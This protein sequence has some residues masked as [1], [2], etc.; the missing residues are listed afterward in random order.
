[1]PSFTWLTLSQAQTALAARLADPNMVFW[2]GP[3]L[4][5]YLCESLRTW[6][7]LTEQWNQ[8]FP[9]TATPNKN[10]YNLSTLPGSP[11]LRTVTDAYLYTVMQYHLLEPP[12]GAG[13]WTGTSQF[14]LA[15]LQFALQRRRDEM[16]QATGCNLT[17][18]PK[19]PS[20]PNTRRTYF[21]DSTLEPIRAR[22]VPDSGSIFFDS[23]TPITLT[24]EDTA[25]WD[26]FE[27]GYL[28]T[29]GKPASWSV[30]AGP[31]LAM[32]VDIA[33]NVAGAYDVIALFS[34]LQFSPPVPT[35]LGVP[36]DWSWLAKWGALA[37]LLGRESEATDRQRADYCLKRYSD[38]LKV[39]RQSNWL[40]AATVNGLVVDTP[41]LREMDGF[42][43]EWEN[44]A[45]AWPS[46]V[47]AGI[48]FVAGCPIGNLMG[49]N[50]LVVGNCPVPVNPSDYVQVSRDVWDVVLDYAQSL[51][52]LKS[53]GNEFKE[54][55]YLE[56]NFF[57][58]AMETN[59]RLAKLGLFRDILGLEGN[60]QNINQPR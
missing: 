53:G 50:V 13:I 4:L 56:K 25:A 10:W 36:D 2:S 22:F 35:L 26:S 59:K 54:C 16:I 31:P 9:F 1:M 30:I 17:N 21:P 46:V 8:N 47:T 3:E 48:D 49:I 44:N 58:L 52:M 29:L 55:A 33:P 18:L 60:R 32:D 7:A 39:M 6:N 20:V 14:S 15:D 24:R 51:A 11:R 38:G 42:S 45:S 34:G 23:S 40:L 19:L 37:D 28:Q 5:M 41:S 43:P 12:T 57:A 27:P